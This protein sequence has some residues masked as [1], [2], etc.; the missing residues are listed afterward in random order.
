M[1]WYKYWLRKITGASENSTNQMLTSFYSPWE[2]N[3]SINPHGSCMHT[4]PRLDYEADWC[5]SILTWIKTTS[6][7][8]YP[9]FLSRGT[10]RHIDLVGRQLE[11]FWTYEWP[12]NKTLSHT[13]YTEWGSHGRD[14]CILSLFENV[15]VCGV[16]SFSRQSELSIIHF[17]TT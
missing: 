9:F 15:V 11:G 13:H 12:W 3:W 14:E 2:N 7:T 4:P 10:Y 6:K 5:V 17:L 8:S 16:G 1:N